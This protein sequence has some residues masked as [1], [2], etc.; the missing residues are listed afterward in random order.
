M[1]IHITPRP[2][3]TRILPTRYIITLTNQVCRIG[4]IRINTCLSPNTVNKTGIF[5]IT[6]H[7][8]NRGYNSPESYCQPP[9]QHPAS[10]TPSPEQPLKESIDW[11][12]R[13]EALDELERRIQILEDSKS[14]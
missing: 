4:L 13:M 14:R 3:L 9:Y 10:Y 2:L 1:V 8:V 7:R 5:I 6:L 11:E 12:K